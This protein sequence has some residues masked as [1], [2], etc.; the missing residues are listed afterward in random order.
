MV[1]EIFVGDPFAAIYY[2]K[3]IFDVFYNRNFLKIHMVWC[4]CSKGG[5]SQNEDCIA[6]TFGYRTMYW[7]VVFCLVL[8][9]LMRH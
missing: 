6:V 4:F 5:G 7:V 8:P 1:I 2:L 9:R 3:S